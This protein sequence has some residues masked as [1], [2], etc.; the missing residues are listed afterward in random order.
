MQVLEQAPELG[1]VGA[2]LQ[3]TPNGARVLRALGLGPAMEAASLRAEAVE[4]HDALTGV[5]IARFSLKGRGDW[6]LFLRADLLDLLHDAAI[7]AGVSIR[8]GARVAEVWSEGAVLESGEGVPGDLV[9]GADGIHSV[10]RRRIVGDTEPF[11]TGQVAWRAL[12]DAKQEPVSRIW[13]AP[14]RHAVTYPLRDGRLNLVA[15]REEAEWA[16]EGW[17][18]R[19]SPDALRAAFADVAPPLADILANVTEVGRWGLFR[20]EVPKQW[21]DGRAVLLGDAAHP[22]LPFLAQ[23][24]NLAIEDAWVLAREVTEH[25]L[26]H[27]LD[28]YQADRRQRVCDA[29]AEANANAKR[30]HLKGASRRGAHL[31]LRTLGRVAPG[32]F[33]RRLDWLYGFDPTADG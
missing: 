13:M 18:H 17:S 6:R 3:V 28:R 19:D 31:A 11:F 33:L 4:P 1:E 12:V 25:G 26:P 7:R 14:G 21:H 2:G 10:L 30:Y 16:E 24:A 22:T 5:R 20:H 9:V 27:G 23:G 29:I 32:A 15:V 8:T